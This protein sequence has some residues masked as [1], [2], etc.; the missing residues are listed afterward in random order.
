MDFPYEYLTWI[1]GYLRE[2]HGTLILQSVSFHSIT[3]KYGPFGQEIGIPFSSPS[4]GGKIVG[5]YGSCDGH[6]ESIGVYLEPV[7]HEYPARNIGPFG[8]NG[9]SPW[10]DGQHSGLRQIVIK[11]GWFIDSIEFVY[12]EDGIA[13]ETTRHGGDGGSQIMVSSLKF[14]VYIL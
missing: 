11:S 5:F 13:L 14:S 2:D 7:S 8:G 6:L 10:D 3:T 12:D 9:G 1:S 4:S